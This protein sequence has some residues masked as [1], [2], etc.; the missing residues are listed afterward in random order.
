ML[1]AFLAH[2]SSFCKTP[3]TTMFLG[4]GTATLYRFV[5]EELGVPFYRDL[6]ED[7]HSGCVIG[8]S[9]KTIGSWISIIHEALRDG[10]LAGVVLKSLEESFVDNEGQQ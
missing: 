10:V 2:R 9:K 5:R 3:C 1:T 6:E 4:R 8:R 7:I